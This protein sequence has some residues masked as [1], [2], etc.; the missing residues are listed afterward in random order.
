VDQFSGEENREYSSKL[1]L[2]QQ[3][4]ELGRKFLDKKCPGAMTGELSVIVPGTGP[5]L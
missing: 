4:V 3:E 2:G 5:R 1:D